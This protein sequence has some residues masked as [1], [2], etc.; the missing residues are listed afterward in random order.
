MA[1]FWALVTGAGREIGFA[2]AEA[3]IDADSAV[4]Q[5]LQALSWL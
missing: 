4:R 5:S 2:I 1:E 3:L